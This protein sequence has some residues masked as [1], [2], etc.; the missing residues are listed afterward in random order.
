MG[1]WVCSDLQGGKNLYTQMTIFHELFTVKS[2]FY[3]FVFEHTCAYARWAHMHRFL[4]VC[5]LTK[6]QTGPKFGLDNNSYL[7]KVAN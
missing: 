4:S 7:L 5:D 3:L 2:M 6:I 1:G